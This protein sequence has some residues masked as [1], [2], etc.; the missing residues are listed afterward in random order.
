MDLADYVI[1]SIF[2]VSTVVAFVFLARMTK[3]AF[4][5]EP[6]ASKRWALNMCLVTGTW[7]LC[8]AAV[9]VDQGAW[10][11][12]IGPGGI[13]LIMI[14]ARWVVPALNRRIG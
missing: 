10:S 12:A 3:F 13:G 6:Q 1:F 4:A 14:A 2:G 9:L 11:S 5:G 7:E 8:V